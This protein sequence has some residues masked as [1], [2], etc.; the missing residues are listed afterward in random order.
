M[1]DFDDAL[2]TVPSLR[3]RLRAALESALEVVAGSP[4]LARHAR[5]F[6][7]SV[8]VIPTVVE[9]TSY[10]PATGSSDGDP[11]RVGWT[12]TPG[13]L[14][15]LELARPAHAAPSHAAGSRGRKITFSAGNV[16]VTGSSGARER[17]VQQ[18]DVLLQHWNV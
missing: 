1:F 15:Y 9:P 6:A 14:P 4:E 16:T 5:P 7:R 13:N 2:Y 18:C 10:T 11:V 12:G 3:D 17:G 8:T